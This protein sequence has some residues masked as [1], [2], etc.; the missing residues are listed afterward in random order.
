MS[1]LY[2]DIRATT[3]VNHQIDLEFYLVQGRV[4]TV[5]GGCG[6]QFLEWIRGKPAQPVAR[7][8]AESGEMEHL[9][10]WGTFCRVPNV[11]ELKIDDWQAKTI[12]RV[13]YKTKTPLPCLLIY[14]DVKAERTMMI[15]LSE[16]VTF[17][18]NRAIRLMENVADNLSMLMG[19]AVKSTLFDN[20]ESK[21]ARL[22][23]RVEAMFGAVLWAPN[24]LQ[25]MLDCLA[26]AGGKECVVQL[27]LRV[28]EGLV[29]L[30]G[31]YRRGLE[32]LELSHKFDRVAGAT[33]KF[34]D[35]FQLPKADLETLEEKYDPVHEEFEYE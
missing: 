13:E 17:E 32:K 18:A 4:Y 19:P 29:K 16:H 3:S 6:P 24:S 23:E 31:V 11:G 15:S 22:V 25:V 1:T 33:N 5:D 27:A 35:G 2:G 21:I 9:H 30:L 8:D 34:L 28:R 14:S 20:W 10:C 26:A 12:R 7:Y